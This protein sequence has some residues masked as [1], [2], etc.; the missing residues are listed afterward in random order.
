MQDLD[1]EPLEQEHPLPQRLVVVH[2]A[3]HRAF[4]DP[5]DFFADAGMT[6]EL[7]DDLDADQRRVHIHDHQ[8]LRATVEALALQADVERPLH[9]RIEER[10]AEL[11]R[12]VPLA[13]K[14]NAPRAKPAILRRGARSSDVPLDPREGF[15]NGMDV[16]SSERKA[17]RGD[18]VPLRRRLGGLTSHGDG[19]NWRRTPSSLA[20][21][22]RAF[23]TPVRGG[24]TNRQSVSCPW[25]D[26]LL[27]GVAGSPLFSQSR[28]D[29]RDAGLVATGHRDET[30]GSARRCQERR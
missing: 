22:S 14:H 24:V 6:S 1:V 10:P 23:N 13:A 27:D 21:R 26:D 30:G 25:T 2:L 29:G 17:D 4:G 19:R 16:R 7:V 3:L 18:H 9:R 8:P 28:Q 20:A 15:G 12:I 11:A 5:G